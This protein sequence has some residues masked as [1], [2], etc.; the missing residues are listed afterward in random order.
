MQH[1]AHKLLRYLAIKTLERYTPKII[2][3]TGSVG[4]TS[5]KQAMF[6]VLS[7]SYRVRASAK[8][9]NNEYGV[10]LTILGFASP[11]RSISKWIKLITGSIRLLMGPPSI[12]PEILLLEM[13]AD[14]PGDISYLTDMA[15]CSVGVITAVS[16]VHMEY[17]KTV[18]GVLK[19]K[20]V[21]ITHLQNDGWALVNGDDEL[22]QS[23][24]KE[25][26]AQVI[27][28]GLSDEHTLSAQDVKFSTTEENGVVAVRGL[29]GKIN[30]D[31]T[32][33]P[34]YLPGVLAYHHVYAALAA[35]A[36]GIVYDINLITVVERLQ[37]FRPPNGRMK[38]L[39]G[40][41]QSCII[42]DTYNSSPE[43]LRS[44][45]AV[46]HDI[47]KSSTARTILVLGDMNE[48]GGS[49]E[50]EH[51]SAGK[52]AADISPD[53]LL[54]YG[55]QAQAISDTAITSGMDAANVMHCES[56][57]VIIER[58][59]SFLRPHDVVLVKGSQTGIRLEKV[60]KAL[61]AH[62][63]TARQVLVRQGPEWPDA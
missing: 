45:L 6:A 61:L 10:A 17:F 30:Y 36:V 19:E 24:L 58:L 43:A 20:K 14:H 34:F 21:M 13:G 35:A 54:T 60:V 51:I 63:D 9:Y 49:A 39:E 38:L 42:D 28:Y 47:P 5:G 26:K 46:A 32:V 2:G 3:V 62:P 40:Y 57:E 53:L 29:Q 18:K 15:P 44:A 22:L 16:A 52:A 41:K 31:G 12:Y 59:K 8:N 11:G 4:K 33:I 23:V 56:H 48:L 25:T 1:I 37:S 7:G 55:A 27:T 50:Y